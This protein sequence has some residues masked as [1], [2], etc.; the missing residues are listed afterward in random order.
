MLF[1]FIMIQINDVK[2][3]YQS[4]FETKLCKIL[5]KLQSDKNF[6]TSPGRHLEINS[7]YSFQSNNTSVIVQ[8]IST[9]IT[10]ILLPSLGIHVL[11]KKM[12]RHTKNP[13]FPF[14][15]SIQETKQLN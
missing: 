14:N 9:S 7:A 10:R 3:K 13:I 15:N 6:Y 1:F 11:I 4:R 5:F 12:Y 8:I 2:F